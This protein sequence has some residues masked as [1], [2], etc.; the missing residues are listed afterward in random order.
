VVHVVDVVHVPFITSP[1]HENMPTNMELIFFEIKCKKFTLCTFHVSLYLVRVTFWI[2]ASQL[3]KFKTLTR[4][5]TRANQFE[6]GLKTRTHLSPKIADSS[7][8]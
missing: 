3:S 6:N 4:V 8:H 2:S 7:H 5:T 1:D